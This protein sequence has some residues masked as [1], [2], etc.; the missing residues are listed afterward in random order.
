MA[1]KEER[2]VIRTCGCCIGRD[3]M[4]TRIAV[5]R[6]SAVRMLEDIGEF[7]GRDKKTIANFLESRDELAGELGRFIIVNPDQE[8]GTCHS[9]GRHLGCI[10]FIDE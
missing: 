3:S 7:S 10:I 5:G 8:K 4:Q 9:G 1:K 2:F 6:V